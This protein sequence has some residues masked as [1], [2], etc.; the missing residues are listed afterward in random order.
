MLISVILSHTAANMG[1]TFCNFPLYA[2]SVFFFVMRM[3]LREV[4]VGKDAPSFDGERRPLG[5]SVSQYRGGIF[6]Q[7]S[8]ATKE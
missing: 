6:P 7:Q 8:V 1:N 2:A 5:A 4:A 3:K